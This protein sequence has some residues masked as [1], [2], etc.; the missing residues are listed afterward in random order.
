[1]QHIFW[2]EWRRLAEFAALAKGTPRGRVTGPIRRLIPKVAPAVTQRLGDGWPME[3]IVS[4]GQHFPNL[5]G[6]EKGRRGRDFR[7]RRGLKAEFCFFLVN[8]CLLTP[9]GV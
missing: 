2:V 4:E 7:R 5:D 8:I 6:E 1:M 9:N 3:R